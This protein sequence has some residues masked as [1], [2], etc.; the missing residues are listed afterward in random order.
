MTPPRHQQ[1]GERGM[2][3]DWDSSSGAD[4]VTISET[5]AGT[6]DHDA[7]DTDPD[8]ANYDSG[9][10]PDTAYR[11]QGTSDSPDRLGNVVGE[12]PDENQLEY[13]DHADEYGEL[14]E[15]SESGDLL[16][17]W[18]D[19]DPDAANY[20]DLDSIGTGS[21][22]RDDAQPDHDADA[23][24][25]EQVQQ[26]DPGAEH[27]RTPELE[28]IDALEAE[29]A[30]S[31]QQL[32]DANQRIAGLEAELK[33]VKDEQS[34][35]FDRLEQLVASSQRPPENT[36][37]SDQAPDGPGVTVEQHEAADSSTGKHLSE[38]TGK[39]NGDK[40]VD[41]YDAR[42]TRWRHLASTE[43]VGLAGA[44]VSATDVVAQ[45]AM[46]ASAEGIIGLTGAAIGVAAAYM[47]KWDRKKEEKK[48]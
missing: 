17:M 44:V 47:A 32:A 48:K 36:M 24:R 39:N 13:G 6:G 9:N 43:N 35:R 41:S 27:A 26:A 28:R 30:D 4:A 45:F 1:A 33:A 11:T 22:D 38:I 2:A 34:A 31:R 15:T 10:D 29:N 21:P 12:D 46:H 20:A 5:S 37:A 7:G 14:P 19:T 25:Q 16:D 42:N 40:Q 8:L 3:A 18:G 23:D